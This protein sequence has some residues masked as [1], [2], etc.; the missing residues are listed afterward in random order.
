RAPTPETAADI[1]WNCKHDWVR[2]MGMAALIAFGGQDA[3]REL[4][5]AIGKR[6]WAKGLYLELL[7]HEGP[8]D[9]LIRYFKKADHSGRAKI[10]GLL[11]VRNDPAALP[12]LRK[13]IADEDTKVTL[14]AELDA[15]VRIGGADVADE[16]LAKREN[17]RTRGRVRVDAA[18]A[19]AGAPEGI[20]G[21]TEA[22][23]SADRYV[24]YRAATG[25]AETGRAAAEPGLL[26]ALNDGSRWVRQ[27]AT[28][29]LGRVGT[30]KAL[31]ALREMA[32]SDPLPHLRAEAAWAI[33][34]IRGK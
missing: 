3:R 19:A 16:A 28:A 7:A 17:C 23:K 8:T 18:L 32:K 22:L 10:A 6:K 21:L 26:I 30:D 13:A 24:R 27:A 4:K 31:P 33:R 2:N 34:C 5:K 29:G 20:A 9:E 14:A 11:A 25:L 1:T 12:A 15:L